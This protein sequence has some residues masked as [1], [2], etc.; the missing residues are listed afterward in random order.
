MGDITPD[1]KRE[2]CEL[3]NINIFENVGER[4]KVLEKYI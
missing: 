2:Y 3:I 4:N 1:A